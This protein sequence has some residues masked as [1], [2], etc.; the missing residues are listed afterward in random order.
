MDRRVGIVIAAGFVA[1]NAGPARAAEEA[2]PPVPQERG[3]VESVVDGDTL[4]LADGRYVRLIGALAPKAAESGGFP[5]GENWNEAAVSALTELA[6]GREIGLAVTG[7]RHDRHGRLLAQVFVNSDRQFWLQGMMIDRGLAHAYALVDNFRCVDVLLDR[8]AMARAAGRGFWADGHP[9]I[10][11]ADAPA[12]LM[13]E[14]GRFAVVEGRVIS[15]GERPR[16]TY[17]NF[18]NNWNEDFTAFVDR[19]DLSRF[20]EAGIVLGEL[21]GQHVRVRGWIVEDRGPAIRL[22]RPEQLQFV[23]K[24]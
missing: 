23:G 9:T 7:I 18:G 14:V 12:G 20:G 13:D 16:R 19:T 10:R 3:R 11:R 8:E 5:S 2:C 4:K 15:V 22:R 24:E 1:A 21:D 17:L 6:E